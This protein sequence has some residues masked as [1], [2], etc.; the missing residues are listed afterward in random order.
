[1]QLLPTGFQPV[2]AFHVLRVLAEARLLGE[3]LTLFLSS[4]HRKRR[5]DA[6]AEFEIEM[7][8]V[9]PETAEIAETEKKLGQ[10]TPEL[11]EDG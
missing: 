7:G 5:Q 4:R 6:A 8:L 11:Q 10:A 2:R 1:M 3:K 9:T